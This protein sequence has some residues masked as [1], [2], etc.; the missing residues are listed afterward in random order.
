MRDLKYCLDNMG[1]S[2]R[3]LTGKTRDDITNGLQECLKDPENPKRDN[4]QN[5]LQDLLRIL[6]SP[7]ASSACWQDLL[8]ACK[9]PEYSILKIARLRDEFWDTTKA[10]EYN[11]RELN[12]LLDGILSNRLQEIYQAKVLL[13]E[14]VSTL[15]IRIHDRVRKPGGLDHREREQLCA[16]IVG[17]SPREAHH[18]VWLLYTSALLTKEIVDAGPVKLFHGPTLRHMKFDNPIFPVELKS[19]PS[20]YERIF[21]KEEDFVMV[22]V[23][24]GIRATTDAASLARKQALAVLLAAPQ[25]ASGRSGT[26][27]ESGSQIHIMDGKI[28]SQVFSRSGSKPI[29]SFQLEPLAHGVNLAASRVAAHLPLNSSV[30][31]DLLDYLNLWD[32]AKEYDAASAILANVRLIESLASYTSDADWVHF[33][34]RVFK[35]HWIWKDLVWNVREVMHTATHGSRITDARVQSA[36]D[37]ARARVFHREGGLVYSDEE[38]AL[39]S[40]HELSE[41]YPEKQLTGY[42]LRSLERDY[43]SCARLHQSRKLLIGRWDRAMDRLEKTRN[44]LTHGGPV[45]EEVL[46]SVSTF[47]QKLAGGLIGISLDQAL[48]GRDISDTMDDLAKRGNEWEKKSHTASTPKSF[49]FVTLSDT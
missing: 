20:D 2:L 38:A 8:R 39:D 21:P 37:Q 47:S 5:A 29:A 41:I 45:T 34:N 36:I 6:R 16:R 31:R 9:R 46:D 30:L 24:L 26:W 43:S 14:D 48:D 49:L 3:E 10:G 12:S 7:Q 15:P 4:I 35:N 18:I 27:N 32:K 33:C 44:A 11:R 28:V 19:A 25:Q 1:T 17:R 22:R 13:G 23:D 42:S 40:L